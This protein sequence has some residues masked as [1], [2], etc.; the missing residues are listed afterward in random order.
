MRYKHL[1]E[2]NR[3]WFARLLQE[4]YPF[5]EMARLIGCHRS[6]VYREY[7]RNWGTRSAGQAY[8]SKVA[9]ARRDS[10]SRQANSRPR[11][12]QGGLSCRA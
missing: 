3:T 9:Q 12:E 5:A 8:S 2:A 7:R 10:R 6:T 1:T 4:G 11:I